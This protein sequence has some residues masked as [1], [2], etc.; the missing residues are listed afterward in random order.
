[1]AVIRAEPDVQHPQHQ[2]EYRHA[3]GAIVVALLPLD[4]AGAPRGGPVVVAGDPDR[5]LGLGRGLG[6]GLGGDRVGGG[7]WGG[8][9]GR[10]RRRLLLLTAR[11][12]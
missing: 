1:M 10:C 4:V 7:R 9:G 11:R 3:Y 2:E 6:R 12:G 8:G 5:G